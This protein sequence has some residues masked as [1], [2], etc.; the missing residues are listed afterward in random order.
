MLL[1]IALPAIKVMSGPK[2]MLQ[3]LKKAYCSF[4]GPE[5]SSKH[6]HWRP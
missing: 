6:P 1:D 5:F 4:R 2:E 3:Q